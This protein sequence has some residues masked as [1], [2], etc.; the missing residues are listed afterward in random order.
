MLPDLELT[1]GDAKGLDLANR[2][3]QYEKNNFQPRF[4]LPCPGTKPAAARVP[5][6]GGAASAEGR[7]G[8]ARAGHT[9]PPAGEKQMC[10]GQFWGC[11]GC[12]V[13]A[14]VRVYTCVNVYINRCNLKGFH[15]RSTS[16][17]TI[18]HRTVLVEND[19]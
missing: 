16:G 11:P 5:P 7:G 2:G 10:P 6:A 19:L 18:N 4:Y 1:P 14:H 12:A 15:C 8:E 3:E 13:N 9:A 17:K